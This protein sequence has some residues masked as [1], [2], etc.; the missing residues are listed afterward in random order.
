MP[1]YIFKCVECK[2]ELQELRKMGDFKEP[3]CQ[4]CSTVI[5]KLNVYMKKQIGKEISFG[6]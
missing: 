1:F 2:S 3:I 5:P 6:V 4:K